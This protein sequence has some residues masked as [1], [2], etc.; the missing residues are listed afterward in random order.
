MGQQGSHASNSEHGNS[1]Q[2]VDQQATSGGD[3]HHHHSSG[4]ETPTGQQRSR[5]DKIFRSFGGK[6]KGKDKSTSPGVHGKNSKR[7]NNVHADGDPQD[8][9]PGGAATVESPAYEITMSPIQ[10]QLDGHDDGAAASA[11]GSAARI[12]RMSQNMHKIEGTPRSSLFAEMTSGSQNDCHEERENTKTRGTSANGASIHIVTN[13]PE[14]G[15]CLGVAP[16]SSPDLGLSPIGDGTNPSSSSANSSDGA[17]KSKNPFFADKD[18]KTKKSGFRL[19]L[20]DKTDTNHKNGSRDFVSSG[21]ENAGSAL[22]SPTEDVFADASSLMMDHSPGE[23]PY[24]SATESGGTELEDS[25][26]NTEKSYD[27]PPTGSSSQ[28]L[29]PNDT[30]DS[31][32]LHKGKS[33]SLDRLDMEEE[34]T[35]KLPRGH[36]VVETK[37]YVATSRLLSTSGS[38]SGS[39]SKHGSS[40]ASPSVDRNK[41]LKLTSSMTGTTPRCRDNGRADSSKNSNT[42]VSKHCISLESGMETTSDYGAVFACPKDLASKPYRDQSHETSSELTWD[43]SD[44]GDADSIVD[45][46]NYR[47]LKHSKD[48]HHTKVK[49]QRYR[50]SSESSEIENDAHSVGFRSSLRS[51][52]Q[53]SLEEII[54]L[55]KTVPEKLDFRQLEKFEG[56]LKNILLIKQALPDRIREN[57]NQTSYI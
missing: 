24:L 1:K 2:T 51:L 17:D 22:T 29:T 55:P 52:S 19:D 57:F 46:E 5:V 30:D 45:N 48:G 56:E 44:L 11:D 33:V 53:L 7:G 26:D 21:S 41:S 18:D 9:S 15:G 20:K 40:V 36:R 34:V 31:S 12:D 42:V 14:M 47:S 8:N 28:T 50:Y 13:P 6:N 38:E 27:R 16:L 23:S 4:T 10:S 54:S 3:P 39:R 32:S 37:H 35:E 43:G 49:K 25:P